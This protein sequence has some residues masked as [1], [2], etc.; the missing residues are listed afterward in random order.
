M[1]YYLVAG[2]LLLHTVFWGLGLSW[3]VLPRRWTNVWWIFAPVLGMAL[4]S[5]VV[6]FGAQTTLPGTDSYAW[7]SEALPLALLAVAVRREGRDGVRRRLRILRGALPVAVVMLSVGAML[8]WPMTQRGA[9]KLS[10]SSLGSCD[11]A[12]YAAGARVFREFSSD[13]R[14][15][16]MGLSEVT[17]VGS[18]ENFFA[19]WQRLNHFTPAALLAHHASLLQLEP[20]QL[21]SLSG[22]VVLLLNVPL[23]LLLARLAGLGAGARLGVAAIYGFSPLSAYGVHHGALG[24]FYAAQGIAVLTLVVVAYARRPGEFG[25]HGAVLLSTLWLLAGSYNFILTVA[26]APAAAWVLMQ[27]WQRRTCR[28]WPALLAW[29]AA[30]GAAC[31]LLFWGRFAGFAERFQLF[32]K[33]DFGWPVPLL[34]PAGWIGAVRDVDLRS[35]PAPWDRGLDVLVAGAFVA[36]AVALVR[37][38]SVAAWSAA[39]LVGPVVG[40]WA[41][42]VWESTARANASYDA[43]KLLAVFYPGLLAGLCVWAASARLARTASRWSRASAAG[44]ILIVAVNFSSAWRYADAMGSPPLRVERPLVELQKLESMPSIR[45]LNLRVEDFWS[46]LWANQFLLRKEQFFVTHTYESRLNTPLRGEWDLSDSLLRSVPVSPDDSLRIN[47]QF[48]VARVAAPGFVRLG[49]GGGWHAPEGEYAVRWRWSRA[50]AEIFIENPALQPVEGALRVRA[51]GVGANSVHLQVAD[52]E[53]GSQA[54]EPVQQELV[55]SRIVL[56]PGRSVLRFRLE[57]PPTP[58]PGDSREL[59]LALSDLAF[60]AGPQSQAPGAP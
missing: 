57:K 25:R 43:Y 7:A 14:E 10:S 9:W 39:A 38:R 18:A 51:R 8:L 16:F 45:S 50:T 6:W 29:V 52:A 42:L 15:G 30:A 3:L 19:Y 55:W 49:F 27:S 47:G 31:L 40:G 41:L 34:G 33:Y 21:V 1:L 58:V 28:H 60:A 44:L 13:N 11:H 56:P 24:Q 2:L 22:V 37:R 48:H 32:E 46:R 36:G 12:D 35:W 59:G 20:Y 17:R 26:F 53:V 4:Q 23:V 5:A 54:L